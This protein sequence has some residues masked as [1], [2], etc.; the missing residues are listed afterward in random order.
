MIARIAGGIGVGVKVDV[1]VGVIV[2]VGVGVKVGVK[3][4]VNVGVEVC[5]I[6]GTGVDVIVGVGVPRGKMGVKTGT[7]VGVGVSRAALRVGDGVTTEGVGVELRQLTVNPPHV[8]TA[9][10]AMATTADNI[11][12][13]GPRMPTRKKELWTQV[14]AKKEARTAKVHRIMNVRVAHPALTT[15]SL[16]SGT[17]RPK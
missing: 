7:V 13:R 9:K 6:A 2:G 17:I 14:L 1:G 5:V 12:L 15:C 16:N 4:G 10:M 11:S 3:A 8:P